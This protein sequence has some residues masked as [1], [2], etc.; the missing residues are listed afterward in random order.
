MVETDGEVE[1]SQTRLTHSYVTQHEV[2]KLPSHLLLAVENGQ[3][4][5]Y[6]I[7]VPVLLSRNYVFQSDSGRD[8]DFAAGKR[9]H[10][11]EH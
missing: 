6:N 9:K 4:I 2:R 5:S 3:T 11:A 8:F 10:P 7:K 1:R